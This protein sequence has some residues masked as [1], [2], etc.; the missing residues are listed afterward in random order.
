[1]D[2]ANLL[3]EVPSNDHHEGDVAYNVGRVRTAGRRRCG[4][5]RDRRRVCHP[6]ALYR[7]TSFQVGLIVHRPHDLY[8]RGRLVTRSRSERC[9]GHG[10][11]SSRSSGPLQRTSPRRRT[12][13]GYF[14]VVRGNNSHDNGAQR[15]FGGHINR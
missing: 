15:N 5:Y 9:N 14:G 10:R 12:I 1:M 7:S 8:Q 6:R 4:F 2:R 3:N 11:R 13:Q